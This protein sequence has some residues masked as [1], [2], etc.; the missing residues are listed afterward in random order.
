[1]VMVRSQC[2]FRFSKE[3]SVLTGA[4]DSYPLGMSS[5][6]L[7]IP[8]LSQ[9]TNADHAL[10]YTSLSQYYHELAYIVIFFVFQFLALVAIYL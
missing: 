4:Q 7:E 10:R 6:C 2:C 8:L 5:P 9:A 3:W 1:M